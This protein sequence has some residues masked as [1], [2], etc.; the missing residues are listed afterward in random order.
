MR[1]WYILTSH[2]PC[3]RITVY[4]T[5]HNN[6]NYPI[7]KKVVEHAS[8]SKTYGCQNQRCF[9]YKDQN[10]RLYN[11]TLKNGCG[12]LAGSWMSGNTSFSGL[13]AL[14]AMTVLSRVLPCYNASG[15]KPF[16]VSIA[17]E[18]MKKA[19]H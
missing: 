13:Q 14:V 3:Y 19:N 11:L 2:S 17:L 1:F 9:L 5:E 4:L 15:G 10:G 6:I 7:L 16:F 8:K 18:F 12:G